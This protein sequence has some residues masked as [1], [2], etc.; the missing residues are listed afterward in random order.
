MDAAAQQNFAFAFL[1]I[2]LEGIP[3]VLFGTIV[4]G[5][6][7]IYMPPGLLERWLPRRTW[8]AVMMASLLGGIF[9][10]CE[11]AIVPVI[12]RLVSKGLPVSCALAFMLAAPIFNPITAYST[13]QAFSGQPMMIQGKLMD[14]SQVMMSLRCGLGVAVACL[15][16][17]ATMRMSL[18]MVLRKEI[19]QSVERE[20]GVGDQDVAA[21][22][23]FQILDDDTRLI[24]AMRSALKDFVDVAVYFTIGVA[25]TAL[26]NTGIAPGAAD[27]LES[28]AGD[29]LGGVA[30]L[31]GLAFVLSLC[32]S[33]DAFIA[34]T[35]A[36]FSY[37]AKLAFLT[38]GPML[39]LKLLFLYQTL[40]R[41]RF[42]LM[43]AL[44]MV[45]SIFGASVLFQWY[46]TSQT[47]P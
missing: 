10:V 3:F 31:M 37:G 4:S 12:R 32:S 41:G 9:P 39:D 17:W 13:W 20:D 36:K 25:I 23:G 15:I 18:A 1:S 16:G 43:M 38:L 2:L 14:A 8:L 21:L 45:L 7:D 5:F 34:A 22:Q 6:I 33:S 26:F 27:W 47:L 35:L 44:A 28:L 40:L 11:C 46:L 24:A 30:A 42:I 19:L 29:S